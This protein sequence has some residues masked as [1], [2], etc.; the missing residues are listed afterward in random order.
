MRQ[1][2]VQP[3]QRRKVLIPDE[4]RESMNEVVD[5]IRQ[6]KRDQESIDYGD[7]IQVGAVCGGRVGTKLRPFVFT[8]YPS[9]DPRH[10]KWYLTL[11]RTEVEDIASGQMT[12]IAMYCCTSPR[13]NMKFREADERCFDCDYE[14]DEQTV[15]VKARLNEIAATVTSKEEWVAEY[16][17][18]KPD[19]S[20]MV[21]IGD[22]NGIDGLGNRLGW[23]SVN[24]AEGIIEKIRSQSS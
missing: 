4:L 7:A 9:D 8:Y 16:M 2:K 24:E 1:E 3:K 15:A 13:C 10:G 21:M 11:H 18:L 17:A 22:Y 23:F 19:A 6:A 5:C 14:D 12:E 20:A